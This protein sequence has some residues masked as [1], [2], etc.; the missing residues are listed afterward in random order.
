[1][2]SSTAWRQ[3]TRPRRWAEGHQQYVLAIHSLAAAL[4]C[5]S[6]RQRLVL[7]RPSRGERRP[8]QLGQRWGTLQG[9]WTAHHV[10]AWPCGAPASNVLLGRADTRRGELSDGLVP[11]AQAVFCPESES[12]FRKDFDFKTLTYLL[13]SLE[14]GGLVSLICSGAAK[15][16]SGLSSFTPH[17][18]RRSANH[19]SAPLARCEHTPELP[20]ACLARRLRVTVATLRLPAVPP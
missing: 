20:C 5:R 8:P 4:R 18:N 6:V 9:A 1:M 13:Q 15:H 2:G 11:L 10:A 12:N 7:W 3:K 16:Q 19:V 14:G 17:V